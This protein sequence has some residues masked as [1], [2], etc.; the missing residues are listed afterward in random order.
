M[1]RGIVQKNENPDPRSGT[2]VSSCVGCELLWSEA[3]MEAQT[4]YVLEHGSSGRQV[5]GV[6]ELRVKEVVTLWSA[7]DRIAALEDAG[8]IL[9][10]VHADQ[11]TRI[12]HGCAVG[13]PVLEVTQEVVH[14]TVGAEIL[15]TARRRPSRLWEGNA[16]AGR[17]RHPIVAGV[18]RTVIG[19]A[20]I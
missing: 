9:R 18:S 4:D 3:L 8:G 5:G 17:N 2:G 11:R 10:V 6:Q 7:V 16:L 19:Q 12:V 13:A 1:K 15:Q 20:G 14:T